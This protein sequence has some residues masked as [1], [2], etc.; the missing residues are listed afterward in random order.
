MNNQ[1]NIGIILTNEDKTMD[2][3]FAE[4]SEAE[5]KTIMDILANHETDGYSVR[6]EVGEIFKDDVFTPPFFTKEDV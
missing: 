5:K 4:F 1:R 6:G 3:V 2:I